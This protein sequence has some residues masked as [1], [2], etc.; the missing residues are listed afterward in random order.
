MEKRCRACHPAEVLLGRLDTPKNWARKVESMITR[1]AQLTPEEVV[2]VNAYLNKNFALVPENVELPEGPGKEALKK[3]CGSCHPAEVVA[4]RDRQAG[5]RYQ[6]A[7]TIDRML[8]LGAKG[9]STQFELI[10]EYL[11][12]H[13]GY[14]PVMTYL[15]EGPGKQ[16]TERV[17]GPCHGA[18]MLRDRRRNAAA[19]SRTVDNMIGRGAI[20]TPEEANQVLEYLSTYLAPRPDSQ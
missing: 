6:W 20:A 8:R 7:A 16:T 10:E 18:I 17:C 2:E 11:T 1:G 4:N 9:D 19:W 5:L 15:P 3:V 13:F 14:L 12:A